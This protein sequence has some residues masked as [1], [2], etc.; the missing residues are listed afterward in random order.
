MKKKLI[1]ASVFL[2]ILTVSAAV[3][4]R[5]AD[6][7][8]GKWK[9]E[10]ANKWAEKWRIESMTIVVTEENNDL[11]V[12]K[13]SKSSV[14]AFSNVNRINYKVNGGTITT[15]IGGFFGGY[16]TR[17]LR[18]VKDNRLQ[19]LLSY[20]RDWDVTSSRETWTISEDGKT[21]TVNHQT[22][23]ISTKTIFTKE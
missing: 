12:E 21:L 11:I 2:L 7:F 15:V 20:Q 1:L 6:N 10:P 22:K 4:Q 17:R 16:E 5:K 8:L 13:I 9:L 3:A 14:N 19:F 18:F 23:Y